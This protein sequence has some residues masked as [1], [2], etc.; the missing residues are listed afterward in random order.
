MAKIDT[1]K[2][3]LCSNQKKE[4]NHWFIVFLLKGEGNVLKPTLSILSWNE[5][6]A[7]MQHA[8]HLC[9]IE[10]LQRFV[11]QKVGEL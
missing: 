11:T 10:C 1:Y 4:V 3:E 6:T 9:G 2:C 5:T 7:A 8:Q